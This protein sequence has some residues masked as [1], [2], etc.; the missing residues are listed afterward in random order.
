MPI[1]DLGTTK[2]LEFG[3]GDIEVAP[4]LLQLDETVGVVCF[5]QTAAKPIGVH[6]DYEEHKLMPI[7]ETP[8]RMTF[9]K[10][11]S[12]DVLILALQEAKRMMINKMV[13]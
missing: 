13:R 6:T 1:L 10:I 4:G 3:T 5:T 11:E 2:Q 9:E 8:V 12:I 7:E